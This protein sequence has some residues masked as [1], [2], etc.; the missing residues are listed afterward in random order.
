MVFGAHLVSNLTHSSLSSGG[1]LGPPSNGIGATIRIG[2]EMLCLPYA[3]FFFFGIAFLSTE[4]TIDL[5]L[6]KSI[7]NSGFP[8]F[9]VNK[10]CSRFLYIS[11]M[12]AH[13]SV[14][15][16][17]LH[18]IWNILLDY[19]NTKWHSNS[20]KNFMFLCGLL[21]GELINHHI[22]ILN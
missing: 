21:L 4:L 20:L 18:R 14:T 22:F 6:S 5:H 19:L 1:I 2:R 16:L 15:P 17:L 11:Y 10:D 8:V 13:A 12:S 9:S 3:G 7:H